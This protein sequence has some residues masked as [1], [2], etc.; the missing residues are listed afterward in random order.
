MAT[1]IEDD[2]E[3]R[4]FAHMSTAVHWTMALTGEITFVSESVQ[5]VRGFS[6]QEAMGQAG[7]EILAPAS[8]GESLRF[9]ERLT[10]DL[11]AGRESE[12][13]R[14]ELEYRC[15]DGSTVW[16]TVVAGLV[17]TPTGEP[18]ELRGVSVPHSS[19]AEGAM[20]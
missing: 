17:V 16:C 7:D 14:G 2:P 10:H 1:S 15:A 11:Q 20:A 12:P 9:F 18:V 6:S 13:F 5:E 8:L 3:F 19:Q 4:R